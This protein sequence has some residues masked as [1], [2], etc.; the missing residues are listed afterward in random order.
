[1][2][3]DPELLRGS[4]AA[5]ETAEITLY[6]DT[7]NLSEEAR[8][9]RLIQITTNDPNRPIIEV[10][11]T[12]VISPDLVAPSAVSDFALVEVS[13]TFAEVQFTASGDDGDNGTAVGYDLRFSNEMLTNDNWETAVQ[14]N[15]EPRPQSAGSVE[16]FVVRG[17]SPNESYF[18]ALRVIDNV[19]LASA[20][21]NNIELLTTSSGLVYGPLSFPVQ[22]LVAGEQA[23]LTLSLENVGNADLA[24]SLDSTSSNLPSVESFF[25][26]SPL[27]SATING[28]LF[29]KGAQLPSARGSIQ[30][31]SSGGSD[32]FGY[33]WID[34]D[35]PNGPA[36]EWNDISA[37]GTPVQNLSDD[38]FL[39]P[40][41]IG[42]DF[43]FYEQSYDE[44]YI[45]TNGF[46]T[47]EDIGNS[48]CCSGLPL[49]N[50]DPFN[51][52]IAWLWYDLV[53][54]EIFYEINDQGSLV[55]QFEN[56][57]EYAGSGKI[58]AQ[59]HLSPSGNIKL[60]YRDIRNDM[61]TDT[62]SIGIENAN[63]TDGLQVSF[64]QEYAKPELAVLISTS[65][66]SVSNTTVNLVAGETQDIRVSI[67]TTGLVAGE[68]SGQV[69]LVTNDP[70]NP[71][72]LLPIW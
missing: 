40:F 24:V 26:E 18:V 70:E 10:I 3:I 45:S 52:V 67:D 37:T 44:F 6:I 53:P 33:F 63:S 27:Q 35:E 4:L 60:L 28:S 42:F 25:N 55:I 71:E 51:A 13:D 2:S 32:N 43:P 29:E 62:A 64:L 1:L 21:S 8:Y 16:R 5:G 61:R 54:G 7:A 48:G 72:V 56:Y 17:F 19:G 58:D 41:A 34:S 20:I 14:I 31:Q 38:N 22:E 30:A 23:E 36:F 47:F 68:Y 9:Q 59:V 65:W 39:G 57:G 11:V 12:I 15:G 49:P 69:R 66:L 50:N 46:I